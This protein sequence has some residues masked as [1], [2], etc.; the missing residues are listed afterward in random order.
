M[1]VLRRTV[2][3]GVRQKFLQFHREKKS[4]VRQSLNRNMRVLVATRGMT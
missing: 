1:A 3:R 2:V 4:P